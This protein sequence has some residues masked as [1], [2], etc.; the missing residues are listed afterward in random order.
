MGKAYLYHLA[1]HGSKLG[2]SE[3]FAATGRTALPLMYATQHD[4]PIAYVLPDE[5]VKLTLDYLYCADD[6]E[7]GDTI[8]NKF[9]FGI[10]IESWCSSLQS[11]EYEE[12]GEESSYHSLWRTLSGGNKTETIT[13]AVT[14]ETT[15]VQLQPISPLPVSVPVIFSEIGCSRELFNRDNDVQPKLVRDWKQL[16]LVS[17]YGLMS[18]IFSGFIAYGYDGGGNSNFRMMGGDNNPLWD[19]KHPLPPSPDYNNFRHQLSKVD[20]I[21]NG[22]NTGYF[23][24]NK[25]ILVPKCQHTIAN[26]RKVWGIDLQSTSASTPHMSRS[27][28]DTQMSPFKNEGQSISTRRDLLILL[29]V[30]S[31][32]MLLITTVH[33]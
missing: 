31:L 1:A 29:L 26:I 27:Q 22:V 15:T 30:G 4:S 23:T 10:N 8:D 11:F 12:D 9:I 28:S 13:D 16:S 14:G 21:N 6:T 2:K 33:R 25:T 18:D 17:K 19:G 24:K 7:D 20:E 5:A 32:I 3:A